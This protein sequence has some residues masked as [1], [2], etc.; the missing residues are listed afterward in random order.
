MGAVGFFNSNTTRNFLT[1]F[2]FYLRPFFPASSVSLCFMLPL[3]SGRKRELVS[4]EVFRAEG[5]LPDDFEGALLDV[6]LSH[7]RA[8]VGEAV[9]DGAAGG[10]FHHVADAAGGAKISC[11]TTQSEGVVSG[12][13]HEIE[14]AEVIE[15]H[16]VCNVGDVDAAGQRVAWVDD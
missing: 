3:S 15:F 5:A 10:S 2:P 6:S 8:V 11:S 14:I 9:G 12:D 7:D 1:P 4:L 13:H 16:L